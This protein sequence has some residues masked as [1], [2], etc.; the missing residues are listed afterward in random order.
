[1]KLDDTSGTWA[2]T[3]NTG[4]FSK[5]ILYKQTGSFAETACTVSIDMP[6]V[7]I[8]FT[9]SAATAFPASDYQL[10]QY[11]IDSPTTS[12]GAT[13]TM[14]IKTHTST[15]AIIDSTSGSLF[16]L[17]YSNLVSLNTAV[18]IDL[19]TYTHYLIPSSVGDINISFTINKRPLLALS[20]PNP[21]VGLAAGQYIK[22][23]IRK[24][25]AYSFT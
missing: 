22:I 1:M 21:G 24:G 13:Y 15:M 3:V 8:L 25:V 20:N 11:G 14:T 9:F 10:V 18:S 16:T 4:G 2:F 5:C 6:N 17:T 12:V 19:Y 7:R 23:N